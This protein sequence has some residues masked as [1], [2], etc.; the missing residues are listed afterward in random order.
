MWVCTRDCGQ[1][2]LVCACGSCVD[3]S[4]G[5]HVI[6]VLMVVYLCPVEQC[7]V[8]LVLLDVIIM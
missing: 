7:H 8:T 1:A 4:S 5:N 3:P 2:C 6:L